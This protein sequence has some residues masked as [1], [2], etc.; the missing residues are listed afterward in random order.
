MLAGNALKPEYARRGIALHREI[1]PA[2][3]Y[4]FF[5][6]DDAVVGG[7]TPEKIALRRAIALGYDR[8]DRHPACCAAD[9]RCRR[10]SSR[11]RDS[12]ATTRRFPPKDEHD[13]AAARALLDKFGYK[14]RDGDGYRE[15]PD[16]KPLTVVLASTTDAAARASDELWKRSMDA[17][18]I[19]ITFVKQ[20]WPELNRMAEAGQLMMWGLGNVATIPDADAFYSLLY[21]GNIGATNYA[22]LRLAEY[23]RALRAVAK[24]RRTT[25]R[26]PRC[27]TG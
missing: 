17:I 4:T 2:L 22:R 18:G 25:A 6:M 9:R 1:E 19:R 15:T 12:P 11:R 7:Y 16:G 20:K 24:P 10:R 5:N 26:A 14:D 21:S 3:S 8:D 23:D 13:P 27:F